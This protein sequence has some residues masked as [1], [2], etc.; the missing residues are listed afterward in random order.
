MND[1][2]LER[3]HLHRPVRRHERWPRIALAAFTVLAGMTAKS[4]AVDGN[5]C[6]VDP[7]PT[8]FERE[9][10]RRAMPLTAAT[11]PELLVN[12]DWPCDCL[13]GG[14]VKFMR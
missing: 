10:L 7:A 9:F 1:D 13:P 3:G 2:L 6:G 4:L 8:E 12:D 14:N 5:H 11:L